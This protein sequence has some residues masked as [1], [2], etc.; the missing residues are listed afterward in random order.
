MKLTKT[1]THFHSQPCELLHATFLL[2]FQE[3]CKGL[4]QIFSLMH[5][6]GKTWMCKFIR[7]SLCDWKFTPLTSVNIIR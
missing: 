2:C 3:C 7:D 1:T 6:E 5:Q 4:D